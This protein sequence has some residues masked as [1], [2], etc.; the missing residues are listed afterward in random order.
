[1]LRNNG[2]YYI[3]S[4]FMRIYLSKEVKDIIVHHV[5]KI[6]F[7]IQ[8]GVT[9]PLRGLLD[10]DKRAVIKVF[11]NEQGNLSLVNEYICY[12]LATVLSLPMPYSGVCFCDADTVDEQNNLMNENMGLGFYSTYLEKN[13]VLKPGIMKH[14]QNKDIFYKMVIF[15]HLIYNKDRNPGNLLVEY[16]KR[17]IFISV[18]DHTHVFKNETI[19]DSQC[20]IRGMEDDDYLDD[21]IME[22][23]S[24][25][26]RMF[27][28]SMYI[29]YNLLLQTAQEVQRLLTDEVLE[30]VVMDVP[31]EWGVTEESLESLRRYLAYRRNHLPQMCGL[32]YDYIQTI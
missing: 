22:R 29:D 23:N 15:D 21:D 31:R 3:V 18:I 24:I 13:T 5:N 9:R 14:I 2:Y 6:E 11:N 17:G 1:M 10:T 4:N 8:N 28:Q 26:Y 12:Q 7:P 27:A 30:T 16:R 19:W 25:I 20:F 32:I